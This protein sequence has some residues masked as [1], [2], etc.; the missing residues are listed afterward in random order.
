MVFWNKR[1]KGWEQ[2]V[3]LPLSPGEP[4][5]E[6]TI[7]HIA[8]R[9]KVIFRS[10]HYK[11]SFAIEH[12]LNTRATN[13]LAKSGR[14]PASGI[15]ALPPR[16]PVPSPVIPW[17]SIRGIR[18]TTGLGKRITHRQVPIHADHGLKLSF[19]PGCRLPYPE[20][21]VRNRKYERTGSL[22]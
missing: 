3:I 14:I 15:R 12:L 5:R 22:E 16:S 18:T 11:I 6:M 20:N 10:A 19:H 21:L 7:C 9:F 8:G 2:G 17:R 1:G 13:Y 4:R